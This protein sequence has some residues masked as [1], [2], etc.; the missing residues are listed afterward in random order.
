MDLML[1]GKVAMVSGGSKGIGLH[2]ARDLAAEG[3]HVAVGARGEKDLQGAVQDINARGKGRAAGFAGDV[4]QPGVPQ[5]FLKKAL[6][7]FGGV[8]ILVNNVGGSDPKPLLE[9]T[10][11]DWHRVFGLNLYHAVALSRLAIPEM[12]KRGG[13]AI[14]NVAS[15]AG[16]ESGSAMTYNA[17]KAALISFTKALAQQVAKDNIRV[18]SLAPG[19]IL[20]PGGIWE[21]RIAAAPDG[22]KGWIAS[23]MP[24]GRMGRPEEVSAVAAFMVSPRAS[25]VHGACWNVDGCQ[26][27][28]NI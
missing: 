7:E 21:R 13:G 11:E 22:L 19:S 1:N 28:S 5:G 14:L 8:D 12:K 20:F 16:R 18:N 15:I 9:T 10:D 27:R 4:T 26:S 17:S 2:I 24:F 6:G 23:A 3:C 25:L